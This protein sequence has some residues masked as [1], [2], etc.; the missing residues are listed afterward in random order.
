MVIK[1]KKKSGIDG[2]TLDN[3]TK[4]FGGIADELKEHPEKFDF[5]KEGEAG[6]PITLGSRVLSPEEWAEKQT[7]R[8]TDA[9][10]DWEKRVLK[11]RKLP[12]E[13]AIKADGKRKDRLAEAERTGKWL[14]KMKK[15][16]V[17]EMYET[18]KKV[19]AAGFRAGVEAR[20]HK[21][22][23]VVNDLQPLV[24][25]AAATLDAMP[26]ATDADREKKLLAARRIMIEI[27]KKRAGI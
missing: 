9:A 7:K 2:V 1:H 23:R 12:T 3:I 13:A 6:N 4:I 5:L 10:A 18:I 11:P 26:T 20:A 15:V 17:D 16:D 22:K 19:G 27:G 21:I 8:A 14:A 24:A 25:A